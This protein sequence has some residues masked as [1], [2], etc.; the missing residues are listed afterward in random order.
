MINEI[1][2]AYPYHWFAG[3]RVPFYTKHISRSPEGAII[4]GYGGV[5]LMD[6]DL[7]PLWASQDINFSEKIIS[8][9]ANEDSSY[10]L[11]AK[12]IIYRLKNRHI[13]TFLYDKPLIDQSI[14][15]IN[16]I[17]ERLL[18]ITTSDNGILVLEKT[19]KKLVQTI[20]ERLA[21]STIEDLYIEN[22]STWW[23]AT[24]NG[25]SKIHYSARLNTYSVLNLNTRL[26]LPSNEIN[27]ITKYDNRI[28]AGTNNG[29]FC[30]DAKDIADLNYTAPVF[31]TRMLVNNEPV[32]PDSI[33]SFAHNYNNFE[34][35]FTALSY[36]SLG[37]IR[38]EYQL[39]GLSN[40]WFTTEDPN[41]R[42]TGLKPG[43]YKLNLRI[44]DPGIYTYSKMISYSFEVQKPVY[45][46]TWFILLIAS[47]ILGVIIY[48]VSTIIAK[49]KSKYKILEAEQHALRSQMNPHFVFNVLNSIQA[50]ILE[51]DK[52]NA[53]LFLSKFSVLIRRV[54]NNSRNPFINLKEEID[55]LR[56]YLEMEHF[57]MGNKLSFSIE[58]EL[59]M[60]PENYSIPGFII[61]PFIENAIWHGISPSAKPGQIDVLFREENGQFICTVTDNGVGINYKVGRSSEKGHISIALKNIQE[62]FDSLNKYMNIKTHFNVIELYDEEGLVSGTKAT[63]IF[64]VIKDA[65]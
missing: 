55:V 46:R 59:S 41:I 33:S 64:P 63:I 29:I 45:A 10:Y 19:T 9:L 4:A 40:Q 42:F 60:G 25:I 8:L 20:K 24:Y 2:G 50:S 47:I 12:G 43:S 44:S 36:R 31:L 34:F 18:A 48:I 53:V 23:A 39:L 15:R 13:D 35:K 61:Q 28:W 62:R 37:K 1:F 6:K 65:H 26:G 38:Y 16:K 3:D 49:S 14:K 11:G 5:V 57:R 27:A 21:S 58:T 17:N 30:F 54:L 52:R 7:K 32:N 22:D 56:S 51:N